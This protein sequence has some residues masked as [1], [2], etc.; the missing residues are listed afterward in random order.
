LSYLFTQIAQRAVLIAKGA[1]Q[2]AEESLAIP[3]DAKQ[4]AEIVAE[5]LENGNEI[6]PVS[7]TAPC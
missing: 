6:V 1:N 3:N 7:S 2:T 4:I 5:I